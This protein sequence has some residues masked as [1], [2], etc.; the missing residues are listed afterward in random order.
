[1]RVMSGDDPSIWHAALEQAAVRLRRAQGEGDAEQ[2]HDAEQDVRV[3]RWKYEETF[4]ARFGRLPADG[5][6]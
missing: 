4:R 3:L 5:E 6:T 2:I 1:M